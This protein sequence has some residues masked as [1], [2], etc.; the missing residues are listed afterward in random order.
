MWKGKKQEKGV[1]FRGSNNSQGKYSIKAWTNL[2][3]V[4][5]RWKK[6]KNTVVNVIWEWLNVW[7]DIRAHTMNRI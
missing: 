1:Q 2:E 4:E 6:L 3:K 5:N 7:R